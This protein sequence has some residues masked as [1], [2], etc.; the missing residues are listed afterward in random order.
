[1][2]ELSSIRQIVRELCKL[3]MLDEKYSKNLISQWG[4]IL[5]HY[6]YTGFALT[7]KGLKILHSY[8]DFEIDSLAELHD[9]QYW[10][11]SIPY[12]F[13]LI[14]ISQWIKAKEIIQVNRLRRKKILDEKSTRIGSAL[15]TGLIQCECGERYY[16]RSARSVYKNKVNEYDYY[17]HLVT[18]KAKE[19]KQRPKSLK[20]PNVNEIFKIFYFYYYLVFDNTKQ[21]MEETQIMIQQE[22]LKLQEQI[23]ALEKKTNGYIKQ[24]RNIL[25]C[26]Q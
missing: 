20:A 25:P 8:M 16:I 2:F 4:N 17:S 19:C 24:T 7:T 18:N 11:A 15:A 23:K 22:Q 14:T 3:K 6:E 9:K 26:H 1:M 10:V 21:L 13:K 5:S 12:P